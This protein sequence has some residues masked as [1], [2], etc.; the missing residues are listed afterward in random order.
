MK[1]ILAAFLLTLSLKTAAQKN[2]TADLSDL[3]WNSYRCSMLEIIAVHSNQIIPVNSLLKYGVHMGM[4]VYEKGRYK[5]IYYTLL[6]LPKVYATIYYNERA[7]KSS[8]VYDSTAREFTALEA[9][10]FRIIQAVE[11]D[12]DADADFK[13]LPNAFLNIIPVI[14]LDSYHAYASW[15][16]RED[17]MLIF[18]NDY[19]FSFDINSVLIS[20]RKVHENITYSCVDSS[21]LGNPVKRIGFHS[22]CGEKLRGFDVTCLQSVYKFSSIYK[23]KTFYLTDDFHIYAFDLKTSQMIRYTHAEFEKKNAFTFKSIIK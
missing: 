5:Y 14:G 8:A 19:D 4:P 3:L 21:E 1:K 23:W 10:A 2:I 12:L 7:D 13:T 11:N 17:G 18:G 16:A 22:H 6:P 15:K 9:F 20:K